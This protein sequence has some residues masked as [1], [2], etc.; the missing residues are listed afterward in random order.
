MQKFIDVL[1]LQKKNSFLVFHNFGKCMINSYKI[2]TKRTRN[3]LNKKMMLSIP[4]GNIS[5]PFCIHDADLKY[6]V[7]SYFCYLLNP[8]NVKNVL[9][10]IAYKNL[11]CMEN[12]YE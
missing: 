12:M 10:I 11:L 7:L 2:N 5:R 9:S 6:R 4:L 1:M 8:F 3:S